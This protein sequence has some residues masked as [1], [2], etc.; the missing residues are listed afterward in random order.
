MVRVNIRDKRSLL[1]YLEVE[2][3]W[4]RTALYIVIGMRDLG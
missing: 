4:G 2:E 1:F 3:G